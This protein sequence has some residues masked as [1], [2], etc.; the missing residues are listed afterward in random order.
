MELAPGLHTLDGT[1]SAEVIAI[2][3]FAQPST[4]TGP[5][6]GV[7]AFRRRTVPLTV[8]GSRIRKKKTVAMTALSSRGRAAHDEPNRRRIQE[9]RRRKRKRPRRGNP[10][11]EETIFSG[12]GAKKM[13][14]KKTGSSMFVMGKGIWFA[15][16]H[17]D[18]R[19]SVSSDFVVGRGVARERGGLR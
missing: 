2:A 12:K 6:A 17:Y 13:P 4:L 3:V 10:K 1:R 5:L 8:N 18:S 15:V 19:A 7:L 11:K 14:R 16:G 9:L